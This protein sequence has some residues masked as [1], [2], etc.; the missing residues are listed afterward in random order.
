M[1]T[2]DFADGGSRYGRRRA[3]LIPIISIAFLAVLR[4]LALRLDARY[5]G[6]S[7]PQALLRIA[8]PT[9]IALGVAAWLINRGIFNEGSGPPVF[10]ILAALAIAGF[11]A[12]AVNRFLLP[13]EPARREP[14]RPA[15]AHSKVHRITSWVI[16][17]AWLPLGLFTLLAY[18]WCPDE[19]TSTYAA[20][21]SFIVVIAQLVGNPLAGV[22]LDRRFDNDGGTML[23]IGR[24]LGVAVVLAVVFIG[25][26]QGLW[27]DG[28]SRYC[29]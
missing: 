4:F 8:G 18:N 1:I 19:G 9:A 6:S 25:G 5:P 23:S 3:A 20:Y 7:A 28:A 14:N 16:T 29:G 27:P 12:L 2:A 11:A 22:Y 24:S 13:G 21:A 15:V 26:S 17:V 10:A